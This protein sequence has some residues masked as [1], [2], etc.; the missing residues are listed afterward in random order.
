MLHRLFSGRIARLEFIF[1]YLLTTGGFIL[2][3]FVLTQI[4]K[5]VSWLANDFMY[6][7]IFLFLAAYF[8]QTS[9]TVRRLRD[10]GWSPWLVVIGILIAPIAQ[11]LF[12]VLAFIPSKK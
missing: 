5:N 4:S 2:V 7:L 9:L 3:I 12:L 1:K 11:I 10:I 6:W 8:Y